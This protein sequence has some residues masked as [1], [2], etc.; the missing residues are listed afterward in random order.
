[1]LKDEKTAVAT[2]VGEKKQHGNGSIDAVLKDERKKPPK[3][4]HESIT[5]KD[6]KTAGAAKKHEKKEQRHDGPDTPTA[7]KIISH[8]VKPKGADPEAKPEV[9][10]VNE[11]IGEQEQPKTT[12]ISKTEKR[13]TQG[14]EQID[15]TTK[16]RVIET[17]SPKPEVLCKVFVRGL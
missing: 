16:I 2:G 7:V 4:H 5:H 13:K 8:E 6:L 1:M 3:A 10:V 14:D 9:R 12:S 11:I 15:E 17:T